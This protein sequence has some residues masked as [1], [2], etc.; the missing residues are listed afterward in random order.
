MMPSKF[1]NWEG[2]PA[3]LGF[4]W[5]PVIDGTGTPAHEIQVGS[6]GK[7]MIETLKEVVLTLVRMGHHVIV[8]DVSFGRCEVDQWREALKDYQVLWIG[9]KAPLNI[10]EEREKER[11]NRIHGSARAQYY[12]VHQD[13]VYNLEFDTSRD[14]LTMIVQTIKEASQQPLP[15][16][17][18]C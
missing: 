1:N 14:S 5:K 13:T 15:K 12:K 7:K 4:S 6:F 18:G 2:G 8:D 17:R 11:G 10:L 9:I 16:E 3:P